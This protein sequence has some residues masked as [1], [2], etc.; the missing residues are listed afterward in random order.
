MADGKG[1]ILLRQYLNGTSFAVIAKEYGVTRQAMSQ[2]IKVEISKL[3][4]QAQFHRARELVVAKLAEENAELKDM[5][6]TRCP[7]CRYRPKEK[8]DRRLFLRVDRLNLSVRAM[9]CLKR[10]KVMTVGKLVKLSSYE[11]YRIEGCGMR[12]AREIEN[13]VR[14]LGLSLHVD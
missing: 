5:I 12:T 3:L 14:A 8:V 1:P 2:R 11:L 13:A 9:N 10:G 6:E 7:K 4:G